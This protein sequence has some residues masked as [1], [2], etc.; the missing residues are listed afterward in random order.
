MHSQI[1]LSAVIIKSDGSLFD[2][3]SYQVFL[4]FKLTY[5]EIKSG[6]NFK[7]EPELNEIVIDAQWE[8]MEIDY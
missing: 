5:F 6:I 4:E 3:H 8:K 1:F 2:A 7:Y